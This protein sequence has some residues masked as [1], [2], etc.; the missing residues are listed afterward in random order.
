M[1]RANRSR[2]ALLTGALVL[3]V[4]A[5]CHLEDAPVI[6]LEP[7]ASA[8][9]LVALPRS[10]PTPVERVVATL[11]PEGG[12]GVSADLSGEGAR[13]QGQVRG[14]R[15]G[16]GT[17]VEATAFGAD[18][19]EVARV[20]VSGVALARHRPGLVVLVPRA[21]SQGEPSANVAP[22]IDAVVA[23]APTVRVGTPLELRAVAGDPNAGDA[24]TYA[25]RAS[26]GEF[27]EP[28]SASTKW[29][30]T[31]EPGAVT[32][33]LQVTD[34]Q[35]AGATLEFVLGMAS[36]A[37][38][39]DGWHVF[40]RAPAL[41]E[42]VAQ[43]SSE[44]SVDSPV[45]LQGTAVDED[46]DVLSYAWTNTCEG[47]F[48]D[49]AAAQA[50]FTPTA[51]PQAGCNCTLTLTVGDGFGGVREGTVA[52]CV[53]RRL[54][55]VIQSTSQSSPGARAGELVRLMATATDP[56][57]E[58]LTFTWAASTGELGT[59]AKT[60]GSGEVDW[61]ALSCL[62]AE[63]QPTVRLTVTNA[64][65]LTA[66]HTFTVEWGGGRCGVHPP[67]TL[68]LADTTVTLEADCTTESTVFIPDGYT[69]DGAGHL[70]TAVDPEGG[71][72]LG[73]V[74][75]NRGTSAHVRNVRVAARG[76]SETRCHAGEDG[77]AGIRLNGA[78]GSIVESEVMDLHQ[79]EGRGGC[80]EGTGIEVRH[81]EDAE[82][83]LEVSV[84]HNRVVGYQKT[85]ILS[86]GRV[87]VRVED[88]TVDGGGPSA[89]IAR[90]GIQVSY[91]AT[92]QVTGNTVLH[93]Q[94][95][96]LGYVAS[97][98]IVAGGPSSNGDRPLSR[99]LFIR[100]NLLEDNDVGI[101]LLQVL[102][103]EGPLSKATN[104]QVVENT[105]SSAA[106][107]NT[108]PY[109]AAILDY[110]GGNL[111]SRNRI[112]GP[113]Y[114][115][116][117]SPG[118][119]FDV[120]VVAGTAAKVDFVTE[121]QAVAAQTC[122]QALVVQSQDAVGN[123]SALTAPALVLRAEG[124]EGVTFY[125][126]AA[127]TLELPASGAGVELRLEA[128]HQEAVF[129]FRATQAGPVTLSVTGEG[130]AASQAQTVE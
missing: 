43:P 71:H 5:G 100:E 87:N 74:L 62:P 75:R 51:V 14:V 69:F 73:A 121:A 65:G 58:P 67:C 116:A 22:Y 35:G 57:N 19:A 107:T 95:T 91:G 16:E 55:P 21:P 40:N 64:S 94:Y 76:L 56:Q 70:L 66:S 115:P 120:D 97:G 7:A 130:V 126:D 85:G 108:Y 63:V 59:P 6:N 84:L 119:T 99:N 105:L 106:L 92:G 109:Q 36:M 4:T 37:Q 9:V 72:F 79:K 68:S 3:A 118:V 101:N 48:S 81:A 17:T 26:A 60:G 61:T 110:G 128:P 129:Y 33:T 32:F 11:T 86:T 96:G 10:L 125:A 27:S 24:V 112:S 20:Q 53:V 83:E 49:A 89:D 45:A 13:W 31:E 39:V 52:L 102:A 88:N 104:I 44:A 41:T 42:L 93:S 114:D 50:S 47:S 113:G 123:L 23:S 127:C 15:S 78:S 124:A 77:L 25:W 29:T 38:S 90:N 18:D 111:I 54:P 28:T 8:R 122:S 80:Q 1:H 12:A 117:T 34:A 2:L 103:D 46:G 30:G 98:I 82:S